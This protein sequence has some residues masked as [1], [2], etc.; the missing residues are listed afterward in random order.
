MKP[1]IMPPP[2]EAVNEEEITLDNIRSSSGFPICYEKHNYAPVLDGM[3]ITTLLRNYK[4]LLLLLDQAVSQGYPLLL[5]R[6][7]EQECLRCFSQ[8]YFAES[9][10]V[11]E[12]LKEHPGYTG[13]LVVPVWDVSRSEEE[14][15]QALR[16]FSNHIGVVCL[17]CMADYSITKLT[18]KYDYE[19]KMQGWVSSQ[20]LSLLGTVSIAEKVEKEA[21][22]EEQK[23]IEA[24]K[25]AANSGKVSTRKR[26]VKSKAE[27]EFEKLKRKGLISQDVL[28]RLEMLRELES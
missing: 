15:K 9:G 5:R 23:R 13:M 20:D 27:I 6:R 11:A 8:Q 21:R 28:D 3:R 10:F 12:F 1:F 19:T 24:A 14:K 18:D 4:P 2:N 26:A 22:I 16:L 17:W 7:I 25:L